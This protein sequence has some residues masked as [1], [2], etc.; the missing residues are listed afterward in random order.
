[1]RPVTPDYFSVTRLKLVAGRLLEETDAV[2]GR[3][4]VVI[5]QA[6]A[7]R[8]FPD[9]NPIGQQLRFF[10]PM[11]WTIVGIVGTERFYGITNA[12]PIAAYMLLSQAPLP[13]PVLLVRTAGDLAGLAAPVRAAIRDIDPA[14]AT[15]A[16]EP[17]SET[18]ANSLSQQRF[19][20]LLLAVFASL[21]L[22][23]AAIG[24]HGVLSYV[25]ARRTKE[26]G[27]R[28]SLGADAG[29]LVRLVVRQGAVLT[30]AGLV[31]G[32][33]LTVASF[34]WLGGLLYEI[35]PT[36]TL[37]LS[38]VVIVIGLVAAVSTWLPARRAVRIDPLTAL[39]Q[40]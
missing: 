3:R 25:V 1:V 24:V 19:L 8:F 27:V 4:A 12:A 9:G 40:E 26:I 13:V 37:T 18:L 34:R 14:L 36:D 39:R 21:A 32:A 15:F 20:M 16:I 6:L 10:G 29:H 5:N 38:G 30:A 31:A 33:V 17:L 11:Q 22:T 23:L 35:T 2:G 7:D 28:M